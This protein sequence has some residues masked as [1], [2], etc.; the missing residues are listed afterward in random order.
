[1][2]MTNRQVL[3]TN[4][5]LFFSKGKERMCAR[6][7]HRIHFFILPRPIEKGGRERGRLL[8]LILPESEIIPQ[9]K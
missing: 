7:V 9:R 1:M 3:L 6:G 8:A 4:G 2:V 5:F